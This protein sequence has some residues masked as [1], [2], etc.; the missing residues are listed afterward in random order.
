MNG[1]ASEIIERALAAH[2]DGDYAAAETGYRLALATAPP[3]L[4][5]QARHMLGMTLL[6]RDRFI[7][8]TEEIA[9]AY[10]AA[11][12]MVG[13]V[14]NLLLTLDALLQNYRSLAADDGAV[15]RLQAV[16]ERV[17]WF[18]DVGGAAFHPLRDQLGRHIETIR[19]VILALEDVRGARR[20]AIGYSVVI[21]LFNM[22]DRI[23]P[24][25]T[26]VGQA[27]KTAA[28][29]A[30]AS[31]VRGEIIV[32]DDGSD[33]GGGGMARA[34]A[35][36]HPEIPMTL[37]PFFRTAVRRRRATPDGG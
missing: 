1:D 34:W 15:D 7:E 31:S 4:A 26:S 6:R 33:D 28:R 23:Y 19:V 37:L 12:D 21:P 35:R 10:A 3:V 5:H 11:P 2:C 8:A 24:C 20:A 30:D 13:V 14:N 18:F 17:V 27:M 29:R 32:V 16:F 36:H 25:L 22:K 9:A